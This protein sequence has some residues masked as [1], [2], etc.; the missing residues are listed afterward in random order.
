MRWESNDTVN[1]VVEPAFT[2][3]SAS[4]PKEV[5]AGISSSGAVVATQV[6]GMTSLA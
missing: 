2:R 6:S 3:L 1:F 5:F 4:Q